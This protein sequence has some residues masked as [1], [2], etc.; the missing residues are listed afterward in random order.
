MSYRIEQWLRP[1]HIK[2]ERIALNHDQIS[3]YGLDHLTNPDP[4]VAAKLRRDSNRHRF[5]K[6]NNGQLFQIELDALQKSP[7][8][9]SQLVTNSVKTYYDESINKR[10]LKEV[11]PKKI[12]AYVKRKVKFL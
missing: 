1:Y 4:R 9:F 10:N 6:E 12:D 7:Q 3:G 2:F 11:T 8:Q 5:L